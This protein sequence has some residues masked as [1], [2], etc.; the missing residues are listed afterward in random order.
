VSK[1]Y[2]FFGLALG[3]LALG[4]LALGW[5]ALGW[6]ALGWL[7]LGWLVFLTEKIIITTIINH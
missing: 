4:W 6:L 5:L 7:A 1:H 2:C 3:W